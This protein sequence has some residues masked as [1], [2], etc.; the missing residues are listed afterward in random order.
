MISCPVCKTRHRQNPSCEFKVVTPT[1]PPGK[2]PPVLL[3]RSVTRK[4]STVV[5]A[6]VPSTP[7]NPERQMK[8]AAFFNKKRLNKHPS[9]K[10]YHLIALVRNLVSKVSKDPTAEEVIDARELAKEILGWNKK[11]TY[12]TWIPKPKREVKLK[13]SSTD[14][15]L[16]DVTLTQ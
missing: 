6:K 12:G 4:G 16:V 15:S 10:Q 13:E 3:L 8:G 14:S 7:P 5:S 9:K 1:N 2:K 11:N